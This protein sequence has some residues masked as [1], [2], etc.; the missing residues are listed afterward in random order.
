MFHAAVLLSVVVIALKFEDES[1]I[2]YTDG[3]DMKLIG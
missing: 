2:I 3:S 1:F